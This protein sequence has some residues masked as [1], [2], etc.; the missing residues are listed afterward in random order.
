MIKYSF[1]L[2]LIMACFISCDK[3]RVFD[4]YKSLPG[5]WNK[6]SI[7]SFDVKDLDSIQNYDLFINI[8][9]TNDYE[10]NNLFLITSM[11]FPHGKVIADTLEYQM[12]YPDGAWMGVGAG[13]NKASKL[14]YKKGVRFDEEGVYTFKIRHAMRKNGERESVENLKGITEVG[15]RIEKPE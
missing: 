6:D 9:N 2:I 3:N 13:D 12:S 10:Y 7:I 8:R 11:N 5:E 4:D 1:L 15:L 14:W